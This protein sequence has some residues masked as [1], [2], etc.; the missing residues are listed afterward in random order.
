MHSKDS[1]LEE[2]KLA[3]NEFQSESME[4]V[5]AGVKANERTGRT[6]RSL[7]GK[8]IVLP[9]NIDNVDI[10][11]C[12]MYMWERPGAGISPAYRR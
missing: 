1:G 12:E 4:R 3:K 9:T 2:T 8:Y 7:I 5:T 10:R 11:P 6:A